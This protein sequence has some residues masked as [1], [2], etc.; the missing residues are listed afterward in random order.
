MLFLAYIGRNPFVNQ[1][2]VVI[3][4]WIYV[5]YSKCRNPFV[6]QVFVVPVTMEVTFGR[7]PYSV[8]I[9]S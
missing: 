5:F 7:D 6:N 8:A 9:P 4:T 1:V 2:F 3:K